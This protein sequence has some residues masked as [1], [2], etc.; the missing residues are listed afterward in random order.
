[1][2]WSCGGEGDPLLASSGVTDPGHREPLSQVSQSLSHRHT[3]TLIS[4]LLQLCWVCA[5]QEERQ[6]QPHRLLSLASDGLLLV[7]RWVKQQRQLTVVAGYRLTAESVPRSLRAGRVRGDTPL[8]G[9][10]HTHM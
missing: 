4:L 8:G 9:T 7:W 1:M 6:Q 10:V 5:P 3:S 2:V